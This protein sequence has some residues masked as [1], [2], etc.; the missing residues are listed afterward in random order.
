MIH[1]INV[2]N[3]EPFLIYKLM[4]KGSQV[5][6]EMHKNLFDPFRVVGM[7]RNFCLIPCNPSGIVVAP[8]LAE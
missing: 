7:Y 1:P 8:F 2:Q 3:N 4:P 5:F 6:D